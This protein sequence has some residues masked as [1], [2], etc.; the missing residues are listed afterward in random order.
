MS[1]LLLMNRCALI[2]LCSISFLPHVTWAQGSKADYDRAQS[3]QQRTRTKV[4]RNRITAN[5]L[6][7]GK[8]F[9]YEVKTGP[10]AQDWVIVDTEQGQRKSLFD[11]PKLAAALAEATGK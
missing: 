2:V 11:G 9:W 3:L 8:Q 4:Y 10:D 5:W 7:G 1:R 6:N